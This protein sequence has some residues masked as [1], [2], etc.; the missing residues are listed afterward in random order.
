MNHGDLTG[1]MLDLESR[2]SGLIDIRSMSGCG[3]V[4]ATIFREPEGKPAL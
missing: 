4:R 1:R 3:A 2:Q